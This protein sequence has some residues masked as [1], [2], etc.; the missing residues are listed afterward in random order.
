MV[1]SVKGKEL[2]KGISRTMH[3]IN[4]SLL[5]DLAIGKTSQCRQKEYYA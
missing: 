5:I 2:G 3:F 4:P 1:K